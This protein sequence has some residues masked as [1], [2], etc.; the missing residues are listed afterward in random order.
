MLPVEHPNI[1]ILEIENILPGDEDADVRFT[2]H[3]HEQNIPFVADYGC[4]PLVAGCLDPKISMLLCNYFSRFRDYSISY[5]ELKTLPT[6]LQL[7]QLQKFTIV[8]I[9][10]DYNWKIFMILNGRYY[11]QLFLRPHLNRKT[12]TAMNRII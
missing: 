6:K 11:I 4:D 5:S 1:L 3:M 8:A 7:Q 9:E 12:Q 2:D 10:V